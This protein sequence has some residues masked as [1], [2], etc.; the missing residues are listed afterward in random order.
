MGTLLD[1]AGWAGKIYSGGWVD[2]GGHTFASVEPAT[3]RQLAEV[4][5]AGPE[6][7]RQ[8]VERAAEAQ[9]AWAATPYDIRATVL[10][11]AADLFRGAPG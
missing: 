8:A 7:V 10:R 2:G 3:E 6:D 11:R 5:A 4:G 1:A 9:R